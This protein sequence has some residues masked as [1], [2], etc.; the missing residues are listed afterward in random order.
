MSPLLRPPE[1]VLLPLSRDRRWLDGLRTAS[2]DSLFIGLRE[3]IMA[4]VRF[5]PP[6]ELPLLLRLSALLRGLLP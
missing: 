6:S 5:T 4:A 1:P 3:R 2:R